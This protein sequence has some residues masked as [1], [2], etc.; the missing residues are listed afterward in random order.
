VDASR[1]IEAGLHSVTISGVNFARQF[2][3]GHSLTDGHRQSSKALSSIV[4]LSVSTFQVQ[5]AT[6]P[7]SKASK[8][9]FADHASSNN[10][11]VGME[12]YLGRAI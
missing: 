11:D 3:E 4:K 6:P 8:T 1:G 10:V 9:C 7:A 5:S 2:V 12:T